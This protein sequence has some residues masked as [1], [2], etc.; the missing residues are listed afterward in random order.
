MNTTT[1][2]PTM[3]IIYRW[4][5][6]LVISTLISYLIHVYRV[7]N[8][9]SRLFGFSLSSPLR[10]SVFGQLI[11]HLNLLSMTSTVMVGEGYSITAGVSIEMMRWMVGGA[12]PNLVAQ[13]ETRI[14]SGWSADFYRQGMFHIYAPPFL[15]NKGLGK[16]R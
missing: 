15:A 1:L 13:G 4:N 16:A 5:R 7:F 3:T 14:G 12:P 11:T 10:L 8:H 6:K 2:F 9:L